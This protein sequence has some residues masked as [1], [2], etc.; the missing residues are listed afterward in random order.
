MR[1]PATCLED[2]PRANPARLPGGS[3]RHRSGRCDRDDWKSAPADFGRDGEPPAGGRGD[4]RHAPDD[5]DSR[6]AAPVEPSRGSQ[7]GAAAATAGEL[8]VGPAGAEVEAAASTDSTMAAVETT[9]ASSSTLDDDSLTGGRCR[10]DD[11]ARGATL[12]R[13]AS[14]TRRRRHH[15]DDHHSAVVA[16]HDAA[17]AFVLVPEAPAIT[18]PKITAPSDADHLDPGALGTS[19]RDPSHH[20]RR[21]DGARDPADLDPGGQCGDRGHRH[22]HA[23]ETTARLSHRGGRPVRLRSPGCESGTRL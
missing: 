15:R 9:A 4:H 20:H 23:G 8:G 2:S 3:R 22:Q 1:V 5:A 19:S 10:A 18:V 14:T 17:A 13:R 12:L 6:D 7:A 11:D 16:E 21:A